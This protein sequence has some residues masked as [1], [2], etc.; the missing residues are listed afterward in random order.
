MDDGKDLEPLVPVTDLLPYLDL[1]LRSGKCS[2]STSVQPQ[3]QPGSEDF[4]CP[5]STTVV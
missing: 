5:L 3:P 4:F 1:V 2:I